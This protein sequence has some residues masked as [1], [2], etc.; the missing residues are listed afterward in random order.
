MRSVMLDDLTVAA[1]ALLAVPEAERAALADKLVT[2]ARRADRYRRIRGRVHPK[3]GGGSVM[4]AAMAEPRARVL[5][6]DTGEGLRALSEI[7]AALLRAQ[8]EAQLT[9]A[10]AVGS[11]SRRLS[12]IS[13]PQSV[14]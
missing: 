5:D 3:W 11:S 4:A 13:S 14:Q 7:L 10:G 6:L 2:H 1:R 8:P 9:Q 12:G